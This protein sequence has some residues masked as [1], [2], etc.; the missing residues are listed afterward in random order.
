M[1]TRIIDIAELANLLERSTVLEETDLWGMRLY[2][3]N[4]DGQDVHITHAH[5]NDAVLSCRASTTGAVLRAIS[6][7]LP[8]LTL[9]QGGAAPA[10]S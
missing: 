8:H 10:H 9:I 3:L 4:L 5:G 7:P 2:F 6:K 1:H